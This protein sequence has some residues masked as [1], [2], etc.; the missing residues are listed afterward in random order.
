MK[1]ESAVPGSWNSDRYSRKV[2]KLHFDF[3]VLYLSSFSLCFVCKAV[4]VVAAAV[5]VEPFFDIF[6][7]LMLQL[8]K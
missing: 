5:V 8:V 4:V 1:M 7:L 2:S 6:F 3:D